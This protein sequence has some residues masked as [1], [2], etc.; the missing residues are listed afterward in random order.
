MKSQRSR[1][2]AALVPFVVPMLFLAGS[3]VALL[4]GSDRPKA[5]QIVLDWPEQASIHITAAPFPV[6]A[7]KYRLLPSPVDQHTGNAAPIYLAAFPAGGKVEFARLEKYLT[8]PLSQLPKDEA[9]HYVAHFASSLQSL[10]IASRR[11]YCRWEDPVR[12]EGL[13]LNLQ[14]VREGR[15][16]GRLLSLRI[17]LEILDRR[18][19]DALKSLQTAFALAR[20]YSAGALFLHAMGSSDADGIEK[21]LYDRILEWIEAPGSPNLYWALA[22][23][24]RPFHDCRQA[25]DMENAAID[26]TFPALRKID[27]LSPEAAKLTMEEMVRIFD[28]QTEPASVSKAAVDHVKRLL[29]KAK[30]F[31][32]REDSGRPVTVKSGSDTVTVLRY[33]ILHYRAEADEMYKWASMPY[34]QGARGMQK[35]LERLDEAKKEN[36]LLSLMPRLVSQSLVMAMR[37]REGALMQCTEA[38]RGYCARHDGN[39]P[40][41][42]E[43]LAPETP[44][45]LDPVLGQPFDYRLENGQAILRAASPTPGTSGSQRELRICVK[46]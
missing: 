26:F 13:R 36:F 7:L 28:G 35:A 41:S 34:W 18:W 45:P 29:P 39:L 15:L 21:P 25:M 38:I 14:Y 30:A 23:L 43:S 24:P 46:P 4:L 44:A 2:F 20:A 9:A 16:L 27:E 42:L 33:M 1:L 3:F 5:K 31:L 12:E 37:D 8:C 32:A 40:P 22:S 17:R 6:P 19:E 11:T 10:E